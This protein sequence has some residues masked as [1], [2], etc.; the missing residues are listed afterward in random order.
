MFRLPAIPPA[1]DYL[2]LK[3]Y[4]REINLIVF[5][6]LSLVSLRAKTSVSQL[7][8]ATIES[9]L[10]TRGWQSLWKEPE[11]LIHLRLCATCNP[12]QLLNNP[13][14]GP[15]K[16]F[17]IKLLICNGLTVTLSVTKQP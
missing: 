3:L 12:Q 10:E 8:Q 16:L 6:S 4:L 14:V 5:Q 9:T 15:E 2:L 17:F 7:I 11:S 1:V 13:T